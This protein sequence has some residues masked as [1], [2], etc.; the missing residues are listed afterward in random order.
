M[1]RGVHWDG[2]DGV[3]RWRMDELYGVRKCV[4]NLHGCNDRNMRQT[5]VA[6]QNCKYAPPPVRRVAK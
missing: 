5:S 2:S 4:L 6:E 3:G 1:V